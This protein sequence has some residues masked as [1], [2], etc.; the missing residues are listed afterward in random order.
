MN[1][2]R[3]SSA[4]RLIVGS[5]NDADLVL[6]NPTISRRHCQL[7]WQ[8]G[9]WHIVDLNSTN[10]T[11]VNGQRLNDKVRLSERD[12]VT[13]GRDYVLR[14]PEPPSEQASTVGTL[15]TSTGKA[16]TR[17]VPSD[18]STRPTNPWLPVAVTAGTIV[19][20]V[21][22][23]ALMS[24]G[25]KPKVNGTEALLPAKDVAEL[26]HKQSDPPVVESHS[27]KPQSTQASSTV[28]NVEDAVWAIVVR[29]ADGKQQR[30]LGSA[31]SVDTHRLVSSASIAQAVELCKA[32]Y[33]ETHFLQAKR[34]DAIIRPTKVLINPAFTKAMEEFGKFEEDF[35]TKVNS[36]Q[37]IEEPTLEDKL[38]WSERFEHV[39][40]DVASSDLAVWDCRETLPVVAKLIS[41]NKAGTSLQVVGYPSL[42][43]SPQVTKDL[44]P[45]LI[46]LKGSLLMTSDPF[47][48]SV[49]QIECS[50]VFQVTPL[51][52]FC[53]DEQNQFLGL[54]VR[55][56]F[57]SPSTT[58]KRAQM[59]AINEF[60]K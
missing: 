43:P 3:E 56:E 54:I 23:A 45:Y 58:T 17:N 38:K 34:A 12:R 10:G 46:S 18:K 35:Q 42:I 4:K 20:L 36:V 7:D 25:T 51:S 2:R 57:G 48:S 26:D 44:A 31:L 5:A 33:P 11:Y 37:S 13:L 30:L 16:P 9:A 47:P 50:S 28:S 29:S 59:I 24:S 15:G 39:M 22:L 41:P 32:E 27:Q 55:H 52:M 6:D 1:Q 21:L 53:V 40:S 14:L 60:W 49:R 8:N 19:V